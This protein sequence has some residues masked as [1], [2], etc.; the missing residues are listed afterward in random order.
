VLKIAT[1]AVDTAA[2]GAGGSQAV[3][4]VTSLLSGA[5][6]SRQADREARKAG[7]HAAGCRGERAVCGELS[8]LALHGVHHFDDL[9]IRAAE[10]SRANIDHLV[11]GPAG[12]FVVDAKNWAGTIT[13]RGGLL[14]QDGVPRDDRI[15][16]LGWLRNRVAEVMAASGYAHRPQ[17]LVVFAGSQSGAAPVVGD[18]LLT[19]V[20]RV[21]D[22][23]S[24]RPAVLTPEQVSGLVELLTY[25]FPPYDVD[26]RHVAEAEGLL[27]SDDETRHAGLR[28]ALSRPAEQW[29]VWLHPEQATSARRSFAGPARIRGAAGTGKTSVALHRVDW[30]ATT[31]PGRFLVTSYVS[32]LP[33]ALQPAYAALS[34]STADRV[35]FRHVHGVALD[36][37]R[38]R[39]ISVDF[40]SRGAAFTAA[41]QRHREAFRDSGLSKSYFQEEV[42]SVLKGRGLADLDSYLRLDRVGRRT[43][44]RAEA[45]QQVWALKETYDAELARQRKHDFVDVLRMARDEVRREPYRKW[46]GIAVDEVQDLPMVGLQL[47]H[48]LAGRDRPDG[49]LLIGDGQQAI[50]PGGFRLVEAGINVTG[51]AV[52]LRTNYRNTVE[53]LATARAIVLDDTYD[54]G[55]LVAEPG[56]RDVEVVRHGELPSTGHYRSEQEHDQA[57]LWDLRAA[58]DRG[59]PWSDIAVLCQTNDLAERYAK[60]LAGEGVPC[61]LLKST[62]AVGADAVKVGTWARSKGMEFPHVFLPLVNRTSQLLTGAGKLAEEEKAELLRRTLYVAM[63]RARDT[64]WVGRV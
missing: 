1:P 7:R 24:S 46:T 56:E 10:D 32:T 8:K 52:V 34:P 49:L 23:L 40:D 44:L 21:V 17:A 30:L 28:A 36:L 41:W 3:Q 22:F 35:D 19:D 14:L 58:A 38:E 25:A 45:R 13:V 39:G 64:L 29:M 26:P 12:V 5:W 18:V 55:D 11:V 15:V 48:E 54:D 59:A 2:M 9:R 53:I 60:L 51:R 61:A 62:S 33:P 27:F 37:L 31:R 6:S 4:A 63:T 50:Y 47:L 43:P 57:L 42:A 16:T 20:T